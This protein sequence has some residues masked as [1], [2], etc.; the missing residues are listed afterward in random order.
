MPSAST[1]DEASHLAELHPGAV[2]V[3]RRSLK[4][5]MPTLGEYAIPIRDGA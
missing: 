5:D 3:S 2:D 1:S 4:S